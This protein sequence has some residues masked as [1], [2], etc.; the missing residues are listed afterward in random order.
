[1][2]RR[3]SLPKLKLGAAA[4]DSGAKGNRP[5][6]TST[7]AEFGA[8]ATRIQDSSDSVRMM[9]RKELDPTDLGSDIF[10]YQSGPVEILPGLYLG[11]EQVSPAFM[12]SA[13]T[14]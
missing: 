10:P 13:Y 3:T 9:S 1:M 14:G 12:V 6:L 11:S 7:A 4:F 2:R 5:L 8:D